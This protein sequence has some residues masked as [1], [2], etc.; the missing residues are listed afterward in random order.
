[1]HRYITHSS[2]CRWPSDNLTYCAID[3]TIL[4]AVLRYKNSSKA[5]RLKHAHREGKE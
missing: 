5:A 1:M 2:T 3:E 4:P